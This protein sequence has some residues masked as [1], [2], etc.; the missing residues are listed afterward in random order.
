[1]VE[2]EHYIG[3]GEV[4]ARVLGM[5]ASSDVILKSDSVS[6]L[7]ESYSMEASSDQTVKTMEDVQKNQVM[8]FVA[9]NQSRF[10]RQSRRFFLCNPGEPVYKPP[11]SCESRRSNDRAL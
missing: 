10:V 11:T 4:E 6:W 3:I 8:L 7:Q 5:K 9:R 2:V 1:M